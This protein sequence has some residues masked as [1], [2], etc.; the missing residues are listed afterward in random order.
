MKLEGEGEG[1][2]EKWEGKRG[3]AVNDSQRS[4]SH[5][6]SINCHTNA[7][8]HSLL[9]LLLLLPPSTPC[10]ASQ[11]LSRL[12]SPTGQVS[13]ASCS[14][15]HVPSPPTAD[16]QETR[17][18]EG[19]R[20]GEDGEAPQGGSFDA[21]LAHHRSTVSGGRNRLPALKEIARRGAVV[22]DCCVCV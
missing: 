14:P 7:A 17:G 3:K 4:S 8:L 2:G 5:S 16:R 20:E 10:Q 1:W 9:L 19:G 11:C 21:K 6:P 13:A 18:G 22:V 12:S 15:C